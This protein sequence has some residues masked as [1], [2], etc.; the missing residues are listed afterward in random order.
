MVLA[1][2]KP[3]IIFNFWHS[4]RKSANGLIIRTWSGI[5]KNLCSLFETRHSSSCLVLG[6][7]TPR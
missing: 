2:G 4:I 7:M 3:P 6:H 5:V 1:F